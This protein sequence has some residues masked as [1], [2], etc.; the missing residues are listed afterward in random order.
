MKT[1]PPEKPFTART[2][3]KPS[4]ARVKRSL[5][6]NAFYR[7]NNVTDFVTPA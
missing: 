6:I 1:K 7:S 4:H 3:I 2:F 5:G